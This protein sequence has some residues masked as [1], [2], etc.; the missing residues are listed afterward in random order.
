MADSKEFARHGCR[1]AEAFRTVPNCRHGARFDNDNI[2][3]LA[4]AVNIA[5][6]GILAS[7]AY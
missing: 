7:L 2:P 4:H 5:G 1:P 3:F 6:P